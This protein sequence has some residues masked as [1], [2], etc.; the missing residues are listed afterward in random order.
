MLDIISNMILNDKKSNH[1]FVCQNVDHMMKV[2]II[3]M[4]AMFVVARQE[5]QVLRKI[6]FLYSYW[7]TMTL[8]GRH[9][10]VVAV[11]IVVILTG[12]PLRAEPLYVVIGIFSQLRK[13][14]LRFTL[15]GYRNAIAGKVSMKRIKVLGDTGH[16][17]VIGCVSYQLLQCVY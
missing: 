14:L 7:E 17:I 11:V 2:G 15:S 10:C 4:G 8:N 13:L 5:I 6:S 3:L 9:F 16:S 1:S 12:Q